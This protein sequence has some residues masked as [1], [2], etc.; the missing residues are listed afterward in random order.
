M[1]YQ[2]VLIKIDSRG[3]DAVKVQEVLTEFGCNIKVRLGLHEVTEEKCAN[4]GLVILE[5]GGEKAEIK[6]M[7]EKLNAIEYVNAQ[8]IEM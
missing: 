6:D 8:H 5:V 4:D 2:I 7:I 3:T 1:T